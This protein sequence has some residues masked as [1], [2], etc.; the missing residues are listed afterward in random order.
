[1][2]DENKPIEDCMNNING[3]NVEAEE[4]IHD[5]LGNVKKEIYFIYKI[6]N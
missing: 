6:S 4:G 3:H 5:E 1:M 2:H